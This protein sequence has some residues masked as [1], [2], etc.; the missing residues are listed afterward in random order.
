MAGHAHVRRGRLACILIVVT[1]AVFGPVLAAS[2]SRATNHPVRLAATHRAATTLTGFA[3]GHTTINVGGTVADDVLV[4]PRAAR[5]VVVQTER[6]GTTR[7]VTQTTAKTTRTGS[8]HAVYRPSGPGLWYY[9]LAFP[10]TA[11]ATA[12]TSP[13]RAVTVVDR[14]APAAVTRLTTTAPTD[15]SARLS[16][17]NPSTSDLSGVRICRV[18]GDTPPA[19]PTQGLVKDVAKTVTSYTDAALTPGTHYAYALF[20][21][22]ASGNYARAATLTLHTAGA[23]DVIPP[24]AVTGLQ[25][26]RT[27]TAVSL[28][29]TNPQDAD[30]AGVVIRRAAGDVAPASV[31]GGSPVHDLSAQFSSYQDSGLDPNTHYSYAVFAYDT[32]RNYADAAQISVVTLSPVTTAVLSLHTMGMTGA[33]L[34][35]DTVGDFDASGSFA[36][37]GTT[38]A[39]GSIDYGDGQSDS[40]T[41][42]FGPYDYWNTVHSYATAGQKTVTLSVTDSAGN[43]DTSTMTVS[44]FAAPTASI[45]MTDATARAGAPVNFA[46]DTA[47]PDGTTLQS[48]TVIVTGPEHFV[49]HFHGAPPATQDLTFSLPGQYVVQFTVTDDAGGS[50]EPSQVVVTVS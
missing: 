8:F 10:A 6:P 18:T 1:A 12:M 45:S 28:S 26:D 16:W 29:W 37:D 15:H 31:T 2:A 47:S 23:P 38:L 7:F 13:T 5:T 44:V 22:D 36:A 49:R 30:F 25:V 39:S 33:K 50:P 27:A 19:R 9:R 41:D 3:T 4:L 35:V 14:T 42:S 43:T 17:T 11:T 46:L 34:T 21:H 40:F 24:A 48:Y 32:V 20:A